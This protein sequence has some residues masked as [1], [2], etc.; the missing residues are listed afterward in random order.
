MLRGSCFLLSFVLLSALGAYGADASRVR[1]APEPSW[2]ESR[3]KSDD[4]AEPP[5]PSGSGLYY[6]L[7]DSQTQVE[8][9]EAYARI[10][11]KI[12]SAQGLQTA[13]QVSVTFDPL[14]EWIDFHRL[15]VRRDGKVENR[16]S[17]EK[18]QVIQQERDLD[19]FQYNGQLT[20]FFVLDDIRV[21][22]VVD[23]SFT[24]RGRNP[25]FGSHYGDVQ[26]STWYAPIRREWIRLITSTE[27]PLAQQQLGDSPLTSKTSTVGSEVV[28]E[29]S[30]SDVKAIT[31][32]PDTPG[33]YM[34]FSFLQ[35]TDSQS[36]QEVVVWALPLYAP[37]E[38]SEGFRAK[39]RALAANAGPRGDAIAAVLD[40][41]Q[42]DI[43]Y[44]GMELGP[45]SHAPG[46]PEH[47]LEV[48]YGDCKDKSRL[49]C[50]LLRE[51]GVSAVPAL[52]HSRR[53]RT[54][55]E[56][57]PSIEAFDHVIVRIQHGGRTYWVDPTLTD[58]SGT[59]ENRA[60]PNYVWALPIAPRSTDLERVENGSSGEALLVP[61]LSYREEP[62]RTKG[63][64]AVQHQ[65]APRSE[66][67]VVETFRLGQP[68][69]PAELQVE[70]TY[71]G[72]AA[73]SMRSY[74]RRTPKEDV[75]RNFLNHRAKLMPKIEPRGQP[76]WQDDEIANEIRIDHRYR[77]PDLWKKEDG[78]Q[79]LVAE[80]Y[81]SLLHDYT[82][83][84][85]TLVRT[86]P[87]SLPYPFRVATRTIVHL[88]EEWNLREEDT[89]IE[90]EAFTGRA[91]VAKSGNIVTLSYELATLD[92]HVAPSRMAEFA[93]HLRQL[94]E[95]LGYSFTFNP[96]IAKRN[97]TF[98]LNKTYL[99]VGLGA[100][101][102]WTA[103]AFWVFRRPWRLHQP[104]LVSP[105]ADLVGLGGW[106]VLVIFGIICRAITQ[107]VFIVTGHRAMFDG[108]VWDRFAAGAHVTFCVELAMQ[109]GLLV[110]FVLSIVTFFRR[111]RIFP[112][113]FVANF[114]GVALFTLVDSVLVANLIG[115]SEANTMEIV[116]T[117]PALV[118]A[119]A[120]WVPYAFVSRRVKA[121]FVHGSASKPEAT[122]P[123]PPPLVLAE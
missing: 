70:S 11:Y 18:M 96:E 82:S 69:E 110:L 94:R 73:D 9:Q 19:R 109:L 27:R 1:L 75:A 38:P 100:V 30:A 60:L 31:V 115:W 28:R 105:P 54:L 57:L 98:R 103:L 106:L 23:Y 84:P 53:S 78:Q 68:G 123:E 99:A 65:R 83:A 37:T 10:V 5:E 93:R 12:T 114:A 2:L 4:A 26:W 71:R 45:R 39:A 95:K 79:V 76:A 48:R 51:I 88:P 108:R 17:L 40:F 35:L 74:L 92:D 61:S 122:P 112:L 116:G 72:L 6:L 8:K 14:Y 97:A 50:A 56:W 16:L 21:G 85:E 52:T 22:D 120:I 121:T 117:V 25:I 86:A 46:D 63:A 119:G 101:I 91:T 62:K 90:D 42:H 77:V 66:I 36:W 32:E 15:E 13:S 58:Q 43:R 34:P 67:E 7:L 104:P 59:L 49:L 55:P 64:A 24:R 44:L 33:W 20:A 3:P 81:P 107:V 41:V 102:G 113:L 118:I 80:L 29:W 89:R 111:H 87:M 47:V